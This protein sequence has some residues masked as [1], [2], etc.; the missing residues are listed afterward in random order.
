VLASNALN[1]G[2]MRRNSSVVTRD[3]RCLPRAGSRDAVAA[4]IRGLPPR[5]DI[6][7]PSIG[8]PTN[9][10]GG[11]YGTATNVTAA[12]LLPTNLRLSHPKADGQAWPSTPSCAKSNAHW[13][14]GSAPAHY[15]TTAS[16]PSKVLTRINAR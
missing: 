2:I 7:Q 16:Q 8:S 3:H 6:D 13:P 15:A 4:C 5:S 10:L 9:V 1:V 11:T 14:F 12:H